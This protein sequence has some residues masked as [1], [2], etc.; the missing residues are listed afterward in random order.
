MIAFILYDYS[1]IIFGTYHM[2]GV[3]VSRP[4]NKFPFLAKNWSCPFLD[5]QS[6]IFSTDRRLLTPLPV[7][8]MYLRIP[9][10]K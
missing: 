8:T 4:D 9:A 1:Y 2:G 7:L 3:V 5:K 6:V 10:L